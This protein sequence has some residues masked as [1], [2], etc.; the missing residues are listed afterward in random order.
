M[1]VGVGPPEQIIAHGGERSMAALWFNFPFASGPALDGGTYGAVDAFEAAAGEP[2]AWPN[3]VFGNH[4][5]DRMISRVNGDG[6]GQE[7]ARVAALLLLTLRGTPFI[8]Y[9][10]EIGMENVAVPEHMLQD[11]ARHYARGRD[12]ERTPMQWTRDG[13]FSS[14]TPWSYGD[15]SR[16][17]QDDAADA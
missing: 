9:G 1:T 4:D 14:A 8:Y 6:R 11:P 3:H 15:L 5:V 13:G 2:G 10:E 16:N 7:R 12:P 17:V